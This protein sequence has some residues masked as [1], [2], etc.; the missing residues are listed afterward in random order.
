MKV[1]QQIAWRLLPLTVIAV[2]AQLPLFVVRVISAI[3]IW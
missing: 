3:T 1:G 2:A